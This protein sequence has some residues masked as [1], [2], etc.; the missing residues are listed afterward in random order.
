M[1]ADVLVSDVT[2]T[3]QRRQKTEQQPIHQSPSIAEVEAPSNSGG[4][5]SEAEATGTAPSTSY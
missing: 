5:L 4:A 1:R 2:K 3:R